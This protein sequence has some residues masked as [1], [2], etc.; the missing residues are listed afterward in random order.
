MSSESISV[1]VLYVHSLLGEGLA[2]L[3]N[4]ETGLDVVPIEVHGGVDLDRALAGEPD[5]VIFEE[6]G[7]VGLE[8][9]LARTRCALL[10]EV[11]LDTGEAWVLRR[12]ALRT[13]PDDLVAAIADACL[14]R[15][16]QSRARIPRRQALAAAPIRA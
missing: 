16:A 14:A 11:S 9:V 6:G 10:I 1:V 15:P 8:K 2:R 4:T 5:A 13:R 7:P 3:L 12:E